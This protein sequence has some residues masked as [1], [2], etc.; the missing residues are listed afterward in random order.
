MVVVRDFDELE[1]LDRSAVE[2][3]IVVYAVDWLGYGKTVAYRGAG[4]ARGGVSS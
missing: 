3:R 1:A 4:A 2:G